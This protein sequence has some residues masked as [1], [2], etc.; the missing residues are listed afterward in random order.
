MVKKHF[1]IKMGNSVF[2]LAIDD[3]SLASRVRYSFADC[4]AS[5]DVLAQSFDSISIKGKGC[6][7]VYRQGELLA[8]NLTE[9]QLAM[10]LTRLFC[11]TLRNIR[12]PNECSLHASTAVV[13]GRAVCF[14]GSSGSGK[15]SMS[16]FVSRYGSYCGDEYAV[17]DYSK[18]TIRHEPYPIQVKDSA[19]G[20]YPHVEYT[21]CLSLDNEGVFSSYLVPCRDMVTAPVD[22]SSWYPIKAIVLPRFEAELKD[23]ARVEPIR[24]GDLPRLLLSSAANDDL[25]SVLLRKILSC[26]SA[27]NIPFYS[28]VYSDG[29][30]AA[31]QLLTL[32]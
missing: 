12:L 4:I 24:I 3:D 16:L 27:A 30:A 11:S 9:G 26:V 2:D 29:N 8:S 7:A 17:M 22:F 1:P 6:Y 25:P 18:G 14:M 19:C 28:L 31:K 10:G 23:K 32:M 5:E 20:L 15:S 13:D 21:R